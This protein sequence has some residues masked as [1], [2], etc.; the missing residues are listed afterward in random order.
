MSHIFNIVLDVLALHTGLPKGEGECVVAALVERGKA[1]LCQK[2]ADGASL[3][4]H[5]PEAILELPGTLGN[6]LALLCHS[7]PCRV[8]TILSDLNSDEV[9]L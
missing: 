3:A 5:C 4:V 9:K 2:S 1:T 8:A 6:V 7:E